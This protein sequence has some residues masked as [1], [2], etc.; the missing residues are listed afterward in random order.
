MQQ[1]TKFGDINRCDD[2]VFL[3]QHVQDLCK[4]TKF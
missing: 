3:L 1:L 2:L 4:E